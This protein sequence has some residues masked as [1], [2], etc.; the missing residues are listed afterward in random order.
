MYI[1]IAT[2]YI[3]IL[4]CNNW[5]I[6]ITIRTIIS[7]TMIMI[8]NSISY[9]KIIICS[10]FCLSLL[11]SYSFSFSLNPFCFKP[12]SFL[13]PS[14]LSLFSFNSRLLGFFSFNSFLL[15]FSFF[16]FLKFF[17]LFCSFFI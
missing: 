13:S 6:W 17:S 5:L 16:C 3:T 1:T 10:N 11:F 9:I 7:S 15:C 12:I 4:F 8:C 2:C 14:L